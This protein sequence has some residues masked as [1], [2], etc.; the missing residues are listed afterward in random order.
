MKLLA[1]MNPDNV[2]KEAISQM[3]RRHGARG[4]I[5]DRQGR[6][7]L[8]HAT[9]AGYHKLPGG[10]IEA[11]ET[12]EAAFIREC[13]EETGF[14][15]AVT[16]ELGR[17]EEYRADINRYQTSYCLTGNAL[18]KS[19]EPEMEVGEIEVGFQAEWYAP[20]EALR[21]MENQPAFS[22]RIIVQRDTLI[23]KEALKQISG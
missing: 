14:A 7:C 9:K 19:A 3:S 22:K 4:V 11:G 5:F 13:L 8:M 2:T 1:S 17:I 18:E 15:I 10:G 20:K 6:I 16:G 12:P 21:I 23:V